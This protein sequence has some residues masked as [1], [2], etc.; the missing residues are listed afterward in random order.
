MFKLHLFF[1]FLAFDLKRAYFLFQVNSPNLKPIF[2]ILTLRVVHLLPVCII[3]SWDINVKGITEPR[4]R[5][6][7]SEV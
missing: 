3:T 7:F 2:H 4:V 1:F 6:R 5:I